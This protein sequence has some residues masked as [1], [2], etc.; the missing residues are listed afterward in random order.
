MLREQGVEG[1]PEGNLLCES[2]EQ[3]AWEKDAIWGSS[4]NRGPLKL[5][6]GRLTRER[7]QSKA[8]RM[9]QDPGIEPTGRVRDTQRQVPVRGRGSRRARP[10][11]AAGDPEPRAVLSLNHP[12][13][14][15]VVSV[16][17]RFPCWHCHFQKQFPVNTKNTQ[18]HALHRFSIFGKRTLQ[19]A[20]SAGKI[21]N[22]LELTD[23]MRDANSTDSIK[24]RQKILSVHPPGR[25]TSSR[26]RRRRGPHPTPSPGPPASPLPWSLHS[27]CLSPTSPLSR[28]DE[29]QKQCSLS[30]GGL[31]VPVLTQW[32]I[33]EQLGGLHAGPWAPSPCAAAQT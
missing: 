33:C 20:G 16:E 24:G 28:A 18:K 13:L 9:Q 10:A 14:P 8:P 32:Q 30:L 1:H 22:D 6:R 12:G 26:P 21:N 4:V 23:I 29:R 19:N 27:C 2:T 11:G 25:C 7:G 15:C 31:E 5:W 17:Q 3:E